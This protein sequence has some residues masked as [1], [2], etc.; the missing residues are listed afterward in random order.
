MT[1]VSDCAGLRFVSHRCRGTRHLR[2]IPIGEV[3]V[4]APRP[5]HDFVTQLGAVAPPRALDREPGRR[6]STILGRASKPRWRQRK[7]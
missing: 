7:P 3:I 2:S 4:D 6:R 1:L 5:R